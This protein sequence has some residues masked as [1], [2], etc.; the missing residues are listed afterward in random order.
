MTGGV[1]VSGDG[2]VISP[3]GL[4]ASLRGYLGPKDHW[5]PVDTRLEILIGSILVQNTNW[6]NVERSLA[7]IRSAGVDDIAR[8]AAMPAPE[9][10]ELIRPSGFQIAK[11]AT[12]ASVAQWAL[13][14]AG[15]DTPP[16]GPGPRIDPSLVDGVDTTRLRAGLR[17]LR[18]VGPET[19]DVMMLYVFDRPTFVADTYARRLFGRLGGAVPKTYDAFRDTMMGTVTMSVP[20]W[21]EF[22]GLIDDYAKQHCRDDDAWSQGPLAGRTIAVEHARASARRKGRRHE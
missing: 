1:D 22:H 16:D 7:R 19:A 17:S 10:M 9:L 12:I 13:A 4:Y 20:E 6:R 3:R 15:C 5:W 11:A 14:A 8:F 2:H 21:Q 18:G